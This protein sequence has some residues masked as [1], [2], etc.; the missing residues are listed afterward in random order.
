MKNLVVILLTLLSFG[1]K[2]QTTAVFYVPQDFSVVAIYKPNE[3]AGFYVGG[4]YMFSIPAQYTYTTPY[5]FVNRFGVDVS[6]KRGVSLLGGGYFTD[7]P[8]FINT[9][10]QP[11]MWVRI[12]FI[13]LLTGKESDLDLTGSIR[14]S[15]EFYYGLGLSYP[16]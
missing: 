5:A 9:T 8:S 16:L 6:I 4:R 1:L 10:F 13:H 3:K 2:A 15:K 11:E 14:I 12:N 7:P